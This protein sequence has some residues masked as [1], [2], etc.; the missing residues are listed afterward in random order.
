M[1]FQ[2]KSVGVCHWYQQ[3]R[4]QA[5]FVMEIIIQKQEMWAAKKLYNPLWKI[6]SCLLNI[7]AVVA[8]FL[9]EKEKG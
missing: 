2:L 4:N 5:Q 6:L 8:T 3:E 9:H 1:L 7:L